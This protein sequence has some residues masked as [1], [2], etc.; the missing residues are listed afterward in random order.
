MHKPV[1]VVQCLSACMCTFMVS[2]YMINFLPGPLPA[3]ST[4]GIEHFHWLSSFKFLLTSMKLNY[5]L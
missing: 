5:K 3:Y 1:L 4:S 2:E